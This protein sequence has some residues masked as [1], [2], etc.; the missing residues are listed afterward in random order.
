MCYLPSTHDCASVEELIAS[1]SLP[2]NTFDPCI[3]LT[4]CTHC[5]DRN[6]TLGGRILLTCS[7]LQRCETIHL[8]LCLIGKPFCIRKRPCSVHFAKKRRS[9]SQSEKITF[10]ATVWEK[11]RN[12][13]PQVPTP[14]RWCSSFSSNGFLLLAQRASARACVR[15]KY[16]HACFLR[17]VILIV[18]V[19]HW[20]RLS[21]V[22][23]P[24][25]RYQRNLYFCNSIKTHKKKS[26]PLQLQNTQIWSEYIEV[27]SLLK[28]WHT[29]L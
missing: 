11:S 3:Q 9:R 15:A 4:Q 29:F 26:P 7:K 8:G 28:S 10:G 6:T 17:T 18:R 12:L 22:V 2:F 5:S 27:V 21:V 20:G 24:S 19:L 25:V 16:T 14:S 13:S 1:H 23:L